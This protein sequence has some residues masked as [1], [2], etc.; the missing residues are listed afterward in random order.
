MWDSY[1]LFFYLD[2][3]YH[4]NSGSF[5]ACGSAFIAPL[6]FQTPSPELVKLIS[7]KYVDFHP[8]THYMNDSRIIKRN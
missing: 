1:S 3:V 4:G 7:D 5:E 8:Q 6:L 2:V